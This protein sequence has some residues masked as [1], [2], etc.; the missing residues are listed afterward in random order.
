MAGRM[1][2]IKFGADTS[3]LERAMKRL[4]KSVSGALSGTVGKIGAGARAALGGALGGFAGGVF[5][6]GLTGIGSRLFGE[7][8]DVSPKFAQGVMEVAETM[9]QELS[10]SMDS[11]A[12]AVLDAK[13]A[14]VEFGKT[15]IKVAED[16]I[17][18]TFGSRR[19]QDPGGFYQPLAMGAGARALADLA[20]GD[21][22][23][24]GMS[25]DFSSRAQEAV[26]F[27]IGYLGGLFQVPQEY[28]NDLTNAITQAVRTGPRYAPRGAAMSEQMISNLVGYEGV[29]RGSM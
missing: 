22:T 14:I 18:G 15:A 28:I 21:M 26:G 19:P 6:G 12:A 16:L 5:A 4:R 17:R 29:P 7:L 13:P 11:F 25:Q 9:R 20:R 2:S 23:G 24:V 1:L 27:G 10:P 8:M 3:R